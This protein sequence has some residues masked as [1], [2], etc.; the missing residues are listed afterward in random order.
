MFCSNLDKALR[1]WEA[2]LPACLPTSN[3]KT[4][5]R[6]PRLGRV[7]RAI[8]NP[9]DPRHLPTRYSHN[10]FAGGQTQAAQPRRSELPPRAFRATESS[11]KPSKSVL[12]YV[13]TSNN[14]P[15]RLKAV[16]SHISSYTDHRALERR[17]VS[18]QRSK[19]S[20]G[21]ALRRSRSMRVFSKQPQIANSNST[22]SPPYTTSKSHPQMSETMTG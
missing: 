8:T 9:T 10:G 2:W 20:T 13:N 5:L 11:C 3:A 7:A 21:L 15:V 14:N 4:T 19:S 22:S 1:V 17:H 12:Q 6:E 18:L 16:I